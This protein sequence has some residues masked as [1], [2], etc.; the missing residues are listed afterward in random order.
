MGVIRPRVWPRVWKIHLDQPDDSGWWRLLS[1]AERERGQR[2]V[3]A[4]EQRR[5]MVAHAALR[6]ILGRESGVRPAQ[7]RYGTEAT[8]RPYL[9]LPGGSPP[10]DFNLSHSGEWALV[11]VTAPTWRVGVDVERIRPDLDFLEM[12]RHMYQP[13]EVDRLIRV[14][15][16]VRRVEYFRIWSAKEAY[17]KAVGIGMAGFRDVLV[18]PDWKHTD[19]AEYGLVLSLSA[20]GVVWP[21]RWLDIAP[22][23][24]AAVVSTYLSMPQTGPP[25]LPR[26][27]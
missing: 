13:T 24:A 15:P 6:A 17:V 22:G 11:A 20:P 12:A 7:V 5:Y 4:D 8:G 21:V 10:L 25:R 26:A 14:D 23:Y 1:D 16:A 18:H 19:D 27:S 3:C 9:A 2:L